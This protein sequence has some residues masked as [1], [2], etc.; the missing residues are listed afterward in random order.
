M[1]RSIKLCII[2]LLV[3]SK[4][5][6]GVDT[7]PPDKIKPGMKGY[8]KTV[9]KGIKIEKFDVEIISVFRNI[10]PGG[11][12]ILA[13]LSGSVISNAG[14]IAGMSGSPV[15]INNKIIGAV[16]FS[17]KFSKEPYCLITPIGEM[18]SMLTNKTYKDYEFGMIYENKN[19]KPVA[20]PLIFQGISPAGIEI[21]SEELKNY[22]L[23]PVAGSGNIEDLDVPDKFEPGSAV[24]VDLVTGDLKISA[25]GTV[26]YTNNGK[27]LL[28]G[29][30]MF[31]SGKIDAPFSFAYIHTVMPSIL[32]SFKL[33]SATKF[34]GRIYQDTLTG[35]AGKI[36]EKPSML[37]VKINFNFFDKFKTYNYKIVDNIKLI[38]M[39]LS[40]CTIGAVEKTG[41]WITGNTLKF[42][43]KIKFNNGKEIN[44]SRQIVSSSLPQSI[45]TL[46]TYI[47]T[48]ISDFFWNRF[49]KIK[50]S[51]IELNLKVEP[52]IKFA[53]IIGA[54][55]TKKEYGPGDKVKVYIKLKPFRK[56]IETRIIEIKLPSALKE[57]TYM[58]FVSDAFTR[59]LVDSYLSPAKYKPYTFEQLINLYNKMEKSTD[60]SV[61][62]FKPSYGITLNG[63]ILDSLPSSYVS[64]FKNSVSTGALPAFFQIESK[65][66]TNYVLT[67]SK[68][69][70]IQIKKNNF[71]E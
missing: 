58:L 46:M 11:D 56:R 53:E 30:S 55:V 23:I 54:F 24:A 7:L 21:F 48:P 8:G 14:V 49:R 17:W 39:L 2:I 66:P 3:F 45:K 25:I 64:I 43:V 71:K 65:I 1:E 32:H 63:E 61:W 68:T 38:P 69:I 35:L 10:R 15:Y 37:P 51:K 5:A 42:N 13:K 70:I 19:I 47:F 26:T 33:G 57:G 34:A 12:L 44:I 60:L 50:I 9:F 59:Q 31:S 62:G 52:D 27:I 20:T 16:A 22:N 41:A 29:H 6:P 28:F 67:G 18:L 36:G 4:L 40:Y